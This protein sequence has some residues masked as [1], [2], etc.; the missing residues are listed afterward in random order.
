[1]G[2]TRVSS[3][4]EE[5]WYNETVCLG[6]QYKYRELYEWRFHKKGDILILLSFNPDLLV[7]I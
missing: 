7:S 4:T 1:M 2:A 6:L 3:P 5:L